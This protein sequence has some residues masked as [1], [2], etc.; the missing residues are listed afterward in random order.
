MKSFIE[1]TLDQLLSQSTFNLSKTTFIL[2]SKR[3]GS[4]LKHILKQKVSGSAFAPQV[5]STEEFIEKITSLQTIDNTESLFKFYQ[6]YKE[7]TP[8]EEQEDFETFYGWAQTLVYD[9]NEIDRYLIDAEHF[10]SYLSRI[11]DINHWALSDPQTNLIEKYLTFWN[12]IPKYYQLF[13]KQLLE[14][15]EAYQGLM[16]RI[17]SEKISSYLANNQEK[18]I[19]LGFNAL[20]NAEQKLFQT[21]L[22]QNK[23]QIFWDIDEAFY[24][25]N[26]HEASLFIRNYKKNWEFY[27]DENNTITTS[28]NYSSAKNINVYGVPKNIGQAKYTAQLLSEISEEDLSKTAIVLNDEGLLN[29]ILNSLPQNIKKLNIT[30]GLPLKET[31]L[32]SLFEVIFEIQQTENQNFYYKPIIDI[33]NHPFILMKLGESSQQLQQQIHQENLVYLSRTQIL[34]L[35]SESTKHLL[36]EILLQHK[37]PQSLL[38]AFTNLC[39]KLRLEDALDKPLETEYL[40][41]FHQLFVKIQNLI[42][43]QSPIQSIKSLHRIS[44]DTLETESLDFSG[45]PFDGLQ[46][47]GM[48]ESRVLDFE[49]IIITSVNEGVLPAGKSSNSFIPFDLKK[50][51]GLPTYKEKDAI[52][53]YHFYRLLQRAKNV[54]ILYNTESGSLNGGEKSRFITQLE[55]ES[56]VGN[57]PKH[58]FLNPLVPARKNELKKIKKTPEVL[59]KLKALAAHG[60]SPSALT[61]YIRNP[62]DFYKNYV[63]GIRDTDEVEETVAAN[64]LGT[65]VHDALEHFYKPFEN[66]NIVKEDLLKMKTEIEQ[67]VK[68]EFEKTYKQA[69]IN[70]GKNLII[71]EIAK[72]YIFNFL[73]KELKEIENDELIIKEVENKLTCD[74]LIPELDFP[75]KI[76]GKVDRVDYKNGQLR[77]V[78]YKTGKVQAGDLN[79]K[80]W[81]ELTKDYKYSKAFQVLCYARM[82]YDETPFEN[83][84]AG[85]ISFKNLKAGF[86]PFKQIKNTVIDKD[87]L[88]QFETE[89]KSLILE[90]FNPEIPFEEK[91]V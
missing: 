38:K 68:F 47:M 62:L 33:L 8:K 67:Q 23:G 76:G 85:I 3:A 7:I 61:T 69:P 40:Y 65:V 18:H 13:Q 21:I 31:P 55:I 28:S 41:H 43:E 14:N 35:S 75:V 74:I 11:Q 70:K 79:L 30:M 80:D 88:N 5:L 10:F 48:L 45:S 19:L 60:F 1:E 72:R 46:L 53:T 66:K 27:Q 24:N 22:E 15:N 17:A 73:A 87:T 52:Y 44:R 58:Q 84:E 56:P 34:E 9:F 2:P 12:L 32:A 89:L 54:H 6:V 77:I 71:F 64:T 83:A 86:M 49:N 81:N 82:I 50:E 25:D 37:T 78:D 51:Y 16:Y 39:Q 90:L 91:E 36:G 20:N 59:E 63:L 26:Y 29:P 42:A 4:F 57:E